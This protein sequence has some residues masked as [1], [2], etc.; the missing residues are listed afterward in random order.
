MTELPDLAVENAQLRAELAAAQR[1]NRQR[2][3]IG[4]LI[5]F[6]IVCFGTAI[7][8]VQLQNA[9]NQRSLLNN[10]RSAWQSRRNQTALD[11]SILHNQTLIAR[12]DHVK[13]VTLGPK[14]VFAPKPR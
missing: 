14:P 6:V 2:I 5:A 7:I 3:L 11:E 13:G 1:P 9:A 12:H 8:L 4:L 10:Q